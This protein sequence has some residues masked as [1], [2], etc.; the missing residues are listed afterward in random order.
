MRF[1]SAVLINP[2][3]PPGYKSNKDSMGGFGQLFSAGAPP[4]PPLDLPYLAAVVARENIPVKVIE[5]GALGLNTNGMLDAL[6]AMT[7]PASTLLCIRTSLPTI[8][9]DLAVCAATKER[10]PTLQI[11]LFGPA[12]GSLGHRVS[13]DQSIDFATIGEPDLA[14][15]ELMRGDPVEG[16]AG[17]MHRNGSTWT[18]NA[19]RKFQRDL[20]AI[21]FP[22][23]DLLPYHNYIIP[24]SATAGA[25]RCLPML[26]SRGC[27]FGC[28]YCPYPVGQGLLWRYRSPANVVDELEHVVRDLGVEYII[29]RDPLFSANKK[30]V[31]A[32]CEEI[33]KRGLTVKW[34]CETR[35]DCLDESTIKIMSEAGCA[36]V[37]F[38]VESIDPQ[39]QKNV[40]RKPIT[41]EQFVTTIGLLRKYGIQTFAFFVIGL[42]GDTV[43]TILKTIAFAI[44]LRASWTQ[45]TVATPFIGT[46]LYD[47]AVVNGKIEQGVYKIISSHEGSM[48][49]ENLTAPEVHR[50]HRFAQILQRNLIN[51]RGVLKNEQRNDLPYRIARGVANVLAD[52]GAHA[53]FW[54]GSM[55]FRTTIPNRSGSSPSAS[56]P[57]V[58]GEAATPGASA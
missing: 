42:P 17:L 12:I 52:L 30:R 4:F 2:P 56:A 41:D 51:R 25:M 1:D 43:E 9:H 45:F 50:L 18:R 33:I 37:N 3:D 58:A 23:W 53:W 27:P 34:R 47:W 36:G 57:V 15:L 11:A 16:I 24:K 48:G 21:P 40:E 32:I 28:N 29:F 7:P 38:G 8:D 44:R 46:K 35:V 54:A 5:A 10:F 13:R 19:E 31:T 22:R 26:T 14:V 6:A 55:F 39:I 49:N 20:D